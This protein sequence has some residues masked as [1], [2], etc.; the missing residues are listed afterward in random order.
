MEPLEGAAS[1]GVCLAEKGKEYIVFLDAA[2]PTKLTLR[3]A[4]GVLKAEW[5]NP[6]T[7]QRH[8]AGKVSEASEL[9]PPAEWGSGPVVLHVRVGI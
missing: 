4:A 7:A 5:F 8:D 1:P 6:F 9:T 3:G 2:A